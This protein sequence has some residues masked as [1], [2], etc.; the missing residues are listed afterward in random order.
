MQHRPWAAISEFHGR[1]E[2]SV[3]VNVVFAHELEQADVLMVE[4]PATPFRGIIGGDTWVSDRS[5]ILRGSV[6]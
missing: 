3:E 5:I 1:E 6:V 2:D 4:P